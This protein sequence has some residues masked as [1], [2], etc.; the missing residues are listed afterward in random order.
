MLRRIE[1][2]LIPE[3]EW[4]TLAEGVL[5]PELPLLVATARTALLA[6]A[7]AGVVWCRSRLSAPVASW[8]RRAVSDD[9]CSRPGEPDAQCLA[10]DA[11]D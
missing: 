10:P 1:A 2:G 9:W 11:A 4:P 6:L 8:Q 7:R 5:E 3:R